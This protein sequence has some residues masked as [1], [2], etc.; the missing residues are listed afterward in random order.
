MS[1]NNLEEL[2]KKIGD[3]EK[4]KE[5]LTAKIVGFEKEMEDIKATATKL[6]YVY[7]DSINEYNR[8]NKK[9]LTCQEE[10]IVK[11]AKSIV[12]SLESVDIAIKNIDVKD[13]KMKIYL[14]G[15]VNV[16]KSFLEKLFEFHISP[17]ET[18]VGDD[19]NPEKHLAI[20]TKEGE[21]SKILEVLRVGYHIVKK[22]DN[23]DILLQPSLVIV[24]A[25]KK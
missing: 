10:S 23:F 24:G 14:E 25:K 16:K 22:N 20:S 2:K 1:D 12:S 7:A 17:V 11:F 6:K 18:K 5:E 13:D 15:L 9:Y 21:E 4:E 19:F 3:L 8:L